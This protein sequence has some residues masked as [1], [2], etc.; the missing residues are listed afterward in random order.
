MLWALRGRLPGNDRNFRRTCSGSLARCA[1]AAV[2]FSKKKIFRQTTNPCASSRI[3]NGPARRL[4]QRLVALVLDP[5]AREVALFDFLDLIDNLA[6]HHPAFV[7]YC[8]INGIADG[9][10]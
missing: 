5:P 1:G 2:C 8:V 10:R 6:G 9:R 3:Q 4:L 7:F